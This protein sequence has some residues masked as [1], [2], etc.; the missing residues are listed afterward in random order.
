MKK[1]LYIFS[2]ALL[3]AG[4]NSVKKNQ[5]LL[6]QGNYE[7][8]IEL[9]VKKLQKNTSSKKKDGHITVL[10]KAFQKN[11]AKDTR[12]IS[13]LEKQGNASGA[14]E[15]YYTY[16][17]LAYIQDKIRPLL[18]IYSNTLKRDAEFTLKDYSSKII[19]AKK[20]YIAYLYVEAGL[21]MQYQTRKDYRTAYNIYCE[22]EDV[23]PN[24]KDVSLKK[25]NARFYGTDF[26]LID[27]KNST[28]QIIPASLEQE[29]L[30]INTYGLDKFWT[31][32]HTQQDSAIDYMYG[33]TLHF[34]EISVAPEK[35]NI[36]QQR[37]SKRIKD[38]WEYVYDSNG[39]VAKDSLG[40]DIKRDVYSTVSATVI[41]TTQSK[42][43]AVGADVIYT[44]LKANLEINRLPISSV[45]VFENI[46]AKYTGD[47]RALTKEDKRF[48]Q[49][50]FID[51]PSNEQMVY[52]T[53]ED[54]KLKVKEIIKKNAF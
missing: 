36:I 35:L 16:Q 38:G 30:S 39:N 22:L 44:N 23:Q 3:L 19:D 21:Y 27:L 15:I 1:L 14:K 17:N 43:A 33:V 31:Q 28:N 8:A 13:F 4:C 50:R 7:Q 10:E 32:Y 37:R 45:F 9:A 41:V 51:F 25:E 2:L 26:V 29:L 52:D 11:V 47:K 49:H 53:G 5:R 48:M 46:F 6:A 20:A 42:S 12:R 54:L 18:P 40:N 24:Y 34:R